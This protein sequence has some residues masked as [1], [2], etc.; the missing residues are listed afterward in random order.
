VHLVLGRHLHLCWR[1]AP[2]TADGESTEDKEGARWQS[3]CVGSKATAGPGR[4]LAVTEGADYCPTDSS[5]S[6]SSS[7]FFPI[8]VH[9][10]LF[11]SSQKS[12]ECELL[13]ATSRVRRNGLLMWMAQMKSLLVSPSLLG[14]LL[15]PELIRPN[16][17]IVHIWRSGLICFRK[18]Q[19][20]N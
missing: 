10:K 9:N 16:G 14:R 6:A 2:W 19:F 15:L 20:R 18:S 4:G 12:K 3:T 11:V 13:D 17:V 5:A 7:K 1:R 8:I